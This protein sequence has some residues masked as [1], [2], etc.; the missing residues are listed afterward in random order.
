[1]RQRI[2]SNQSNTSLFL[3]LLVFLVVS[4]IFTALKRKAFGLALQDNALLCSS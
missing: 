3:H 2:A 1:M 4:L